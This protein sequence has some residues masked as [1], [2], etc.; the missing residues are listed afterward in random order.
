MGRHAF[1]HR[2]KERPR[3]SIRSERREPPRDSL[4]AR[5]V[6]R[7]TLRPLAGGTGIKGTAGGPRSSWPRDQNGLNQGPRRGGMPMRG[8]RSPRISRGDGPPG[9]SESSFIPALHLPRV[10]ERQGRSAWN[11]INEPRCNSSPPAP[12][13]LY[14]PTRRRAKCGLPWTRNKAGEQLLYLPRR[15]FLPIK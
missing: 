2:G 12:P 13:D 11:V 1:R 6:P 3:P 14:L 8:V 15:M 10:E 7:W 9:G 5:G 4:V